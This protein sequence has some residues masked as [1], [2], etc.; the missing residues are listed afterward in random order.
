MYLYY[1]TYSMM[2]VWD[3]LES[4][5]PSELNKNKKITRIMLYTNVIIHG[6]IVLGA[7]FILFYQ[8]PDG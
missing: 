6:S 2:Y 3:T 7:I 4:K 1:F 5:S 8:I